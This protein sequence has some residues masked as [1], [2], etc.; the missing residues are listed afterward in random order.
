MYEKS[1]EDEEL[2]GFRVPGGGRTG[3]SWAAGVATD[4]KDENN[5]SDAGDWVYSECGPTAKTEILDIS[6]CWAY[7]DVGYPFA[8]EKRR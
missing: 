3:P 4:E 7:R 8:G 5:G 2:P 6:I 1:R